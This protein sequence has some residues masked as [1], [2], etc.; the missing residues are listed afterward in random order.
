MA[1]TQILKAKNL[2]RVYGLWITVKIMK[3]LLHNYLNTMLFQY[4]GYKLES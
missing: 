3:Y 2:L 1:Y 4:N